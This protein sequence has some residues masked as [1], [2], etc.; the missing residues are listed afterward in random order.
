MSNPSNILI[1]AS[2]LSADFSQIGAEVKKVEKAGIDFIHIDI[3]DGHFVPNITLGPKI[4]KDLRKKTSLIL[5]SHLMIEEPLKF[6]KEFIEAGS[7]WITL[8]IEVLN[9]L[10]FKKAVSLIKRH[11]RKI[12]LSLNP[13][14]PLQ[15]LFPYFRDIDFVLIM[16]VHPGFGG[17]KFLK[18]SLNKIKKLRKIFTKDIAVDGGVNEKTAS[19]IIK[20]GANI[21]CSGS[22]IFGSKNYKESI[23]RLR[24]C[25]R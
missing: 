6:L 13:E 10:K 20:A 15:K 9:T 12:G 16:S 14:T 21:L 1:G 23:R 2:I 3:M 19:S 24:E 22:Y 11:K 4:V 18:N 7:D 5:D 25:A 17:Q 8:H